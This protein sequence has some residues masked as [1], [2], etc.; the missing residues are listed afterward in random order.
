VSEWTEG[1]A[2]AA[3]LF[4]CSVE[5]TD[6]VRYQR[7]AFTRVTASLSSPVTELPPF[8]M[9]I[10]CWSHDDDGVE[11]GRTR[12]CRYLVVQVSF[13]ESLDNAIAW[14]STGMASAGRIGGYIG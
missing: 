9:K 7:A 5:A 10:N 8:Q 2:A 4:S 11:E 12:E 3:E 14:F 1:A 13:L 6:D